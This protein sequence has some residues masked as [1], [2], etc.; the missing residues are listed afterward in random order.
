MVIIGIDPGTAI[1]GYAVIKKDQKTGNPTLI[2]AGSIRPE[3]KEQGARLKEIRRRFLRLLD[4]HKPEIVALEKIFFSKN[5]RTAISVAEARG[6]LLLTA[7]EKSIKV[8]EYTPG[9]IKMAVAGYGKADKNQVKE[10]TRLILKQV[11]APKL[12]DVTDATAIAITA[13]ETHKKTN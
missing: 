2:D 4:I 11:T 6:V 3:T 10:M 7:A 12:D 13:L 1:T 5:I 8:C 9:E